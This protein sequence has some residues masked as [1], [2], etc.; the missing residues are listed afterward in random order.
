MQEAVLQIGSACKGNFVKD[1][2]SCCPCVAY[3]DIILA[4]LRSS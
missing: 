4:N 2:Y 1:R 3:K